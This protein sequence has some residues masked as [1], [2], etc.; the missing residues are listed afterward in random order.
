MAS[1]NG[2][3]YI[4]Y[5]TSINQN[6][7]KS[8]ELFKQ[9]YDLLRYDLYPYVRNAGF[10][11]EKDYPERSVFNLGDQTDANISNY[12]NYTRS[13]TMDADQDVVKNLYSS[14]YLPFA[15][16]LYRVVE[17]KKQPLPVVS[18]SDLTDVKKALQSLHIPP[19]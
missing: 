15:V 4:V 2:V 12:R 9:G 10:I 16:V 7:A 14:S 18:S 19:N 3:V 13:Y 5:D 1:D 17:G 11:F 8:P 6:G